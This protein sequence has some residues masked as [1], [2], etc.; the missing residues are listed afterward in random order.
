MATENNNIVY[1]ATNFIL[2]QFYFSLLKN[3]I[4]IIENNCTLK[5]KNIQMNTF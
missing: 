5:L 2:I 4:P 3:K 1:S